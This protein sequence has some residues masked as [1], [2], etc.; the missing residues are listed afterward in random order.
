[1]IIKPASIRWATAE[2]GG[3][4]TGPPPGPQYSAPAK[5]VAHA[6]LWHVDA[7]DLIVELVRSI[8]DQYHWIADVHFRVEEA[9]HEWLVDGA[10][11]ELYEGKRCV[12]RGRIGVGPEN[13]IPSTG[14]Q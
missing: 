8:G 4:R 7:F 11:F 13:P 1:M 10:E 14:G 3:R 6:A 2:E 9:P 12:A 5:F